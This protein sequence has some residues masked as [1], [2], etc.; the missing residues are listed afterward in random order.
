[1]LQM[2]FLIDNLLWLLKRGY[3]QT[4]AIVVKIFF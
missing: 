1:M 3:T 2:W 4:D